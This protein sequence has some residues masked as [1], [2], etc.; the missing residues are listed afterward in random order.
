MDNNHIWVL[1]ESVN[2]QEINQPMYVKSEAPWA[3][4]L[5]SRVYSMVVPD[6]Q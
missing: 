4:F 6:L 2:V 1:R 5:Y 3:I